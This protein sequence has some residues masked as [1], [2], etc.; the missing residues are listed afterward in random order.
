MDNSFDQL[1]RN[2]DNIESIINEFK[3]KKN[4][5]IQYATQQSESRKIQFSSEN[6]L[7]GTHRA[8]Y[9]EC[10]AAAT[11]AHTGAPQAYRNG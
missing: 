8:R 7:H 2:K 9:G 3:N 4:L 6:E 1:V 10:G 11:S 5:N